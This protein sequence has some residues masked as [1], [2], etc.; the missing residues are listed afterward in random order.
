AA[1]SRPDARPP[2]PPSPSA[3][4]IR[5]NRACDRPWLPLRAAAVRPL[6]ACRGVGVGPVSWSWLVPGMLPVAMWQGH[7]ASPP[8]FG[9]HPARLVRPPQARPALARAAGRARRSLP[10]MA[11]GDHAATDHGGGR[12][13]VFPALPGALAYGRGPRRRRARRGA[14][15]L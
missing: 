9:P 6:W 4:G 11:L 5:R 14:R 8:A 13:S 7:G 15:G 10:R 2:P 1:R 12:G 3:G